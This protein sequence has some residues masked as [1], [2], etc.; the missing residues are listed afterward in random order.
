MGVFLC[1]LRVFVA[2]VIAINRVCY[3][4]LIQSL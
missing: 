2:G 4:T 3:E 1:A